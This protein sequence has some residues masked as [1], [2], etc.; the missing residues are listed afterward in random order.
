MFAKEWP[1]LRKL[2]LTGMGM[3]ED[4]AKAMAH[5]EPRV[6]IKQRLA[7][8]QK[9]EGDATPMQISTP[10]EIYDGIWE[11]DYDEEVGEQEGGQEDSEQEKVE[12]DS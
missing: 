11:S 6:E 9:M 7:G 1:K 12:D 5:L 8:T 3:A 2:T 10:E 4:V